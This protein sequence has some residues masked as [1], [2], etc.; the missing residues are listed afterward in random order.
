MIRWFEFAV[1]ACAVPLAAQET[2]QPSPQER[3][4]QDQAAMEKK[5]KEDHAA[6]LERIN[7]YRKAVGL[8]AVIEDPSLSSGCQLH[9]DYLAKNEGRKEVHEEGAHT[10]IESLPGFSKEGR[11]AGP[12]SLMGYFTPKQSSFVGI[13]QCM[14]SLYHRT[15]FSFPAW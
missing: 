1:L 12:R 13:D 14:A 7:W 5:L 15:P 6:V 10:E 2:G 9:A 3:A 4:A 8:D 11:T